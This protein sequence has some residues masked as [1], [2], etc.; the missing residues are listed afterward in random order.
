M[1]HARIERDMIAID[2][3][4]PL[5]RDTSLP[6]FQEDSV[7]VDDVAT[8]RFRRPR[9]R[10][11]FAD[12]EITLLCGI[13]RIDEYHCLH[14]EWPRFWLHRRYRTMN[15]HIR[16]IRICP[17]SRPARDHFIDTRNATMAP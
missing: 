1:A 9:E 6:D 12:P 13:E 2:D 8:N 15:I 17:V 7:D 16:Q 14:D 11:Q 3:I 10:N 4:A 5:W